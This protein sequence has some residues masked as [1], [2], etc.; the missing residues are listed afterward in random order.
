[1]GHGESSSRRCPRK[2]V[3]VQ[4]PS[5]GRQTLRQVEVDPGVEDG[6]HDELGVVDPDLGFQD[7]GNDVDVVLARDD[8]VDRVLAGFV[9]LLDLGDRLPAPVLDLTAGVLN[10]QFEV[11]PRGND[12]RGQVE[13]SALERFRDTTLG[14]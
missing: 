13:N 9:Q 4:A 2:E 8:Q 5:D 14:Q 7:V 11:L 12:A 10:H 6:G 1:M 3:G